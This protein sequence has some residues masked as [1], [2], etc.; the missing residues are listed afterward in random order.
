MVGRSGRCVLR[1]N[2]QKLWFIMSMDICI[3]LEGMP[4]EA[5][6]WGQEAKDD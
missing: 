2:N 6:G 3:E 4:F 1:K 5:V